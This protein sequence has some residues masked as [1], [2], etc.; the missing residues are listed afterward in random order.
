M[1]GTDVRAPKFTTVATNP[2]FLPDPMSGTRAYDK[3]YPG[4]ML[5]KYDPGSLIYANLIR[6]V[7][8]GNTIYGADCGGYD[9][10]L[11]K[12]GPG[13]YAMIDPPLFDIGTLTVESAYRQ[14]ANMCRVL[15]DIG[16][17]WIV[18]VPDSQLVRELFAEYDITLWVAP[19]STPQLNITNFE[20]SDVPISK[21]EQ[22]H[23]PKHLILE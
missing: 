19:R 23:S 12:A 15:D 5:F 11:R 22:P 10:V 18:R 3:P 2:L 14:V 16:V 1:S 8:P 6:P 21:Y 4:V 20:I 13:F 9:V 17:F 7:Q